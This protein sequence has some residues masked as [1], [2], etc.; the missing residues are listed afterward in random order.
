MCKFEIILIPL[1]ILYRLIVISAMC[2]EGTGILLHQKVLYQLNVKVSK[3]LM[4]GAV[5]SEIYVHAAKA[6]II[7]RAILAKAILARCGQY[8]DIHHYK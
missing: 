8:L 3:S 4:Y 7:A 6:R 2:K 1:N 5:W